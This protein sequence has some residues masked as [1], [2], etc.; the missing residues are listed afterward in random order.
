[1]TIFYGFQ[2]INKVIIK[3]SYFI[4]LTSS[5]FYRNC[6]VTFFFPFKNQSTETFNNYSVTNFLL[7]N[8]YKITFFQNSIP[9]SILVQFCGNLPTKAELNVISAL[10]TSLKHKTKF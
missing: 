9:N 3:P 8:L 4:N 5:T 2:M 6:N 1:M 7:Y 10:F